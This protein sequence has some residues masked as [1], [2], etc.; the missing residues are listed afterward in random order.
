MQNNAKRLLIALLLISLCLTGCAKPRIVDDVHLVQAIGYD[1]YKEN[2]LLGTITSPVYSQSAGSGIM[3]PKSDVMSVVVKK[4]T[5]VNAELESE[6]EYQLEPGKLL[7][8]LYS[9]EIAADGLFQYVDLLKRNPDIGIVTN[10]AI[11]EG[12]AKE[13]LEG[14]YA[15][16]PLISEYL[17]NMFKKHAT[18][19]FPETNLHTFLYQYAGKGMDPFLPLIKKE[20]EHVKIIGIALFKGDKYIDYVPYSQAFVFNML[21]Q[22]FS[23][24][25]YA[26]PLNASQYVSIE[27]IS[28][29]VDYQVE[30]RGKDGRHPIVKISV[31]ENGYVRESASVLKGKHSIPNLQKRL[32]KELQKNGIT[33]IKNFKNL[34]TDPLQIGSHVRS[35]QRHWSEAAWMDYYP[36]ADIRLKVKVKLK[37]E[38]I[39]N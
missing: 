21:Y 3:P 16:D 17:S 39:T 11:T 37:H 1:Y 31:E 27:N 38:G 26:V 32:A 24:G 15:S 29:K 18:N 13:I 9:N 6:S 20:N 7:V 30:P 2:Y 8:S 12:S 33:L 5:E 19:N 35:F 22:S 28:S 14:Q 25:N 23:K 36:H 10:L 34:R 4:G